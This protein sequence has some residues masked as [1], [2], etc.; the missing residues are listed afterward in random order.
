MGERTSSSPARLSPLC[1]DTYVSGTLPG[2]QVDEIIE[3]LLDVRNG[4]P[5]KQVQLAE[6]EI[7]MLC[8]T[9]KEIFMSQP[10]LLELE[11]PIKICG[12]AEGDREG[13]CRVCACVFLPIP[14]T[15]ALHSPTTAAFH[16][17]VPTDCWLYDDAHAHRGYARPV[18]RLAAPLRVRRVPSGGQL[19]VPGGLR[20]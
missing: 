7:R 16:G 13:F 10:N 2:L 6:N 19:L 3:R 5:G 1:P 17:V 4:R 8:L 15:S 12:E 14:W 18:L 9:A 20:G 11:A